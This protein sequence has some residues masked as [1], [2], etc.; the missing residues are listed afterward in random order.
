MPIIFMTR[1]TRLILLVL[2]IAI[3]RA[4]AVSGQSPPARRRELPTAP[5]VVLPVAL[6][7]AQANVQEPSDSTKAALATGVLVDRLREL[8]GDQLIPA[9]RGTAIAASPE[10]RAKAGD[11]SCSVIVACA[12]LVGT[13]LHAPWAVMAKVSKTSN[14]IWLFTGQLVQVSTGEILLD[15]S[16]ELKGEPDRMVQAG[17]RIFAERVARTVRHGGLTT[18]FPTAE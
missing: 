12:R 16:T 9:D 4:P 3:S 2:L 13:T 11:Q 18:N 6:Y 1:F 7:T 17:A 15:D 5:V 8:L 10:A 14:L